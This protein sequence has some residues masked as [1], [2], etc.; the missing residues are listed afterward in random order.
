MDI[1]LKNPLVYLSTFSATSK[2]PLS[3]IKEAIMKRICDDVCFIYY[4]SLM[5]E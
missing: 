5:S 1:L 3:L 2:A 4:Y